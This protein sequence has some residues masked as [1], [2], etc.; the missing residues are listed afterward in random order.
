MMMSEISR[1][2]FHFH[3][4]DDE[5]KSGNNSLIL[6]ESFSYFCVQLG[7]EVLRNHIELLEAANVVDILFRRCNQ[8]VNGN[9]RL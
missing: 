9:F 1:N 6:F 8:R 2:S 3:T 7:L 4:C 5:R